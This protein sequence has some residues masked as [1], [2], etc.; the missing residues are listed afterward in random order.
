MET[1]KAHDEHAKDLV[2]QIAELL[3]RDGPLIIGSS[4]SLAY[5]IRNWY[6][7]DQQQRV[8]AASANLIDASTPAD[9]LEYG[10]AAVVERVERLEAAA[11]SKTA[12]SLFCDR[13][14][15]RF[16]DVYDK[17]RHTC[18]PKWDQFNR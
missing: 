18:R 12:R 10:L 7:D 16:S 8:Q 13:C 6:T 9:R 15:T 1:A 2:R 3:R 11:A 5:E 17:N 14:L 4:S